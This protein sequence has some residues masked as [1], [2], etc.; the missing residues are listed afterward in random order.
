MFIINYEITVKDWKIISGCGLFVLF[1]E[2]VFC[3]YEFYLL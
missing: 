1:V 3:L 2:Y